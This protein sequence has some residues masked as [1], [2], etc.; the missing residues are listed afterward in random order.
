MKWSGANSWI[1]QS[2]M[3][4]IKR[5]SARIHYIM[6][7]SVTWYGNIA[8]L[9]N[10]VVYIY[11]C[12]IWNRKFRMKTR[13]TIC[14]SVKKRYQLIKLQES[15][16]SNELGTVFEYPYEEITLYTSMYCIELNSCSLK[17]MSTKQTKIWKDIGSKGLIGPGLISQHWNYRRVMSV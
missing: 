17:G 14:T 4:I 7:F 10:T 9:V 2:K 8:L 11:T 3:I 5:W 12:V 15:D 13:V 6:R 16:K 1:L